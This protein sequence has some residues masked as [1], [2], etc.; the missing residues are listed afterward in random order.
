[1]CIMNIPPILLNKKE[2]KFS[3]YDGKSEY[4]FNYDYKSEKRIHKI[5]NTTTKN[6]KS[7]KVSLGAM[8]TNSVVIALFTISPSYLF[9]NL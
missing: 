9:S 7:N 1:M 3:I 4:I 5:N 2:V 8:T 6:N